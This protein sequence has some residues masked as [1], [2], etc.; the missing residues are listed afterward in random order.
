MGCKDLDVSAFIK[1]RLA[2]LVPLHHVLSISMVSSD[3]VDS[4]NLLH[5][6]EHHLQEG[7]R[8]SIS[9]CLVKYIV[10]LWAHAD[11]LKLVTRVCTGKLPVHNHIR[12]QIKLSIPF[13][14]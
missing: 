6:L 5:S 8:V 12:E 9:F 3:Y 2:T 1:Q 10:L 4:T 11:T 14:Y 7:F 13:P